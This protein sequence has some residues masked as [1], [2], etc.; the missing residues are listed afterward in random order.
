MSSDNQIGLTVLTRFSVRFNGTLPEEAWID[1]RFD[2]LKRI[3]FTSLNAQ[4]YQNFTWLILS[5]PEWYGKTCALFEQLHPRAG[6]DIRVVTFP[7]AAGIYEEL[8][9]KADCFVTLRLDSDDAVH[10]DMLTRLSAYTTSL[11]DRYLVNLQYGYKLDLASGNMLYCKYNDQYQ[12]PFFAVK[13]DARDQMF[14]LGVNHRKARKSFDGVVSLKDES[15]LQL[16]HGSNYRNKFHTRGLVKKLRSA[17][18]IRDNSAFAFERPVRSSEERSK[19]LK[20]FGIESVQAPQT[21]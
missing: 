21:D 10:N 14:F 7:V 13:H 6:I 3:T 15:W 4:T 8:H 16:I 18:G 19:V 9:I 1:S 2:L 12:G 20:S 17:A 5:A 11:P